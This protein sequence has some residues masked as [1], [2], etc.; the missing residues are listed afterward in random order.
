MALGYGA[1][2]PFPAHSTDVLRTSGGPAAA[3]RSSVGQLGQ[4]AEGEIAAVEQ[5]TLELLE[6][7]PAVLN[8]IELGAD[9]AERLV[10]DPPAD[11]G[12]LGRLPLAAQPGAGSLGL[13]QLRE[14]L[15]REPEQVLEPDDLLDPI[16]FAGGVAAVLSLLALG[17][18]GQQP[19]LLVVADRAR[20]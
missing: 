3:G 4:A 8:E 14:L 6:L 5:L 10:E 15:E 1:S 11:G 16:D 17:R 19:D 2:F 7:A 12:I 20:A 18:A 13:E 9:V